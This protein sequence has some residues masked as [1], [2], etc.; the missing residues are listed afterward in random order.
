MM[1]NLICRLLGH[2]IMQTNASHRV[3]LRCGQK[4][5]RRNLGNVEA[6]VE[7][8]AKTAAP[9]SDSP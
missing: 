7:T 9:A 8:G 6:W 3:C 5:K 4:E 1:E 2:D